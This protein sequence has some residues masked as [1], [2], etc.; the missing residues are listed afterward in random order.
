MSSRILVA[1]DASGS[2]LSIR[3]D[4]LDALNEFINDQKDSDST[5]SLYLFNTTVR[6]ILS[7][8]HIKDVEP[9]TPSTYRC[10]GCTALYDAV[11]RLVSDTPAD[12]EKTI[13]VVITDGQDNT[14]VRWDK[15]SL[16]QLL[17]SK[18]ENEGWKVIYLSIGSES[19]TPADIFGDTPVVHFEVDDSQ[20]TPNAIS[21]IS[22]GLTAYIDSGDMDTMVMESQLLR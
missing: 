14:S 11:G 17:K 6:P 16:S 20:N 12:S 3:Y 7:N 19:M 13:L 8:V 4:A 10:M 5:L 18:E 9:I 15:E 22:R 21:A 2:M 1:F